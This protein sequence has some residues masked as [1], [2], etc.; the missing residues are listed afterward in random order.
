MKKSK[1]IV[2]LFLAL[3]IFFVVMFSLELNV[4][5]TADTSSQ[6]RKMQSVS[7]TEEVTEPAQTATES[8]VEE[9]LT[10]ATEEAA[11]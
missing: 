10:P 7:K 4:F 8:T 9:T 6:F 1:R 11:E 2:S 5:A 3:V